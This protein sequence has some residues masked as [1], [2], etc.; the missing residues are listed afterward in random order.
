MIGDPL[1]VRVAVKCQ[2]SRPPGFR[3][4]WD[5]PEVDDRM[6]KLSSAALLE[7]LSA[8]MSILDSMPARMRLWAKVSTRHRRPEAHEKALGPER[9]EGGG[10]T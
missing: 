10:A 9:G 8:G 2:L 1:H 4:H 6:S 3:A 5:A 7:A